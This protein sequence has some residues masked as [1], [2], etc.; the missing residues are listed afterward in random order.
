MGAPKAGPRTRDRQDG[1]TSA[2]RGRRRKG[3]WRGI[4][5]VPRGRRRTRGWT[6]RVDGRKRAAGHGRE[7]VEGSR[8][9]WRKSRGAGAGARGREESE[10]VPRGGGA[11]EGGRGK[12]GAMRETSLAMGERAAVGRSVAQRGEQRP[13]GASVRRGE[14]R[15]NRGNGGCES[16]KAATG[17]QTVVRA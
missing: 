11:G 3:D 5:R 9:G 16:G 6:H 7:D 2:E 15:E 10:R 4:K 12:R 1:S 14:P 8:A 13:V 17:R